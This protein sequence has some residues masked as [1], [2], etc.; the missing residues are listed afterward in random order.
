MHIYAL[1]LLGRF[2]TKNHFICSINVVQT[3][4]KNNNADC[5]L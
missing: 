4:G 1:L 3:E 2:L 5:K